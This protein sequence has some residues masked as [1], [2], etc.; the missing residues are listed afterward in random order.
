M[1]AKF[2]MYNHIGK[3][4]E[5]NN[6]YTK[7]LNLVSWNNREPVYDIRTWNADH[8][9][10]KEGVTITYNEMRKFQK[11]LADYF[12]AENTDEELRSIYISFASKLK[13]GS[14][15]EDLYNVLFKQLQQRFKR[16]KDDNA[17]PMR[18]F[19]VCIDLL[20]VL[21]KNNQFL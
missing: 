4:C 12:S 11:L 1:K 13:N 17:V 5:P 16:W 19:Q 20:Y 3:L 15:D 8:S 10:W 7:E 9:E 14:F 6:G 2:T 21:S 18:T